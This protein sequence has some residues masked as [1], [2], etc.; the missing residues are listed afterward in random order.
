MPIERHFKSGF[1][2]CDG[3]QRQGTV[4]ARPGA[5]FLRVGQFHR[6]PEGAAA[7]IVARSK[8][9]DDARMSRNAGEQ[10]P[11]ASFALPVLLSLR[12]LRARADLE[13][14]PSGLALC[15]IDIA[16]GT[17]ADFAQYAK[18]R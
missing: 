4:V 13:G 11:S 17:A 6:D 9:A 10:L 2:G 3:G 1:G 7:W 8:Q 15:K 14:D 16:M 5:G 18:R 12:R